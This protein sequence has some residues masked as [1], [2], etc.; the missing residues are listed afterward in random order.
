[1]TDAERISVRIT[2]AQEYAESR[3][4][5]PALLLRAIPEG[6]EVSFTRHYARAR[7]VSWHDLC[8]AHINP[9]LHAIDWICDG[10]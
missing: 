1:M 5:R 4:P 8:L 9:L 2:E 3:D 7:I 10:E 6:L